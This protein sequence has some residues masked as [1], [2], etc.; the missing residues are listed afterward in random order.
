MVQTKDKE[1]GSYPSQYETEVA[2][3]DGSAMILRPIRVDDA[4][5]W[6]AFLS[7]IGADSKYLWLHHIP[8]Q[9]SPEDAR[10]FC[11]VDYK[12]TFAMIGEVLKKHTREIVAVG[13][14]YRL[15]KKN[16]AEIVIVIEESYRR[17]G[18]G[19][20]LM[21]WLANA[22]RGNNISNFEADVSME[23][24]DMISLI[25]GYGFHVDHQLETGAYHIAFPIAR[26]TN[27]ERKEEERERASSIASIRHLL[28]PQ[29]VALIGVSRYPGT[30]G[31]L[32]MRCMLQGGFAGTVYPVNPNTNSVM[33]VRTYPS[34]MDIPDDVDL[35]VIAVPARLVAKIADECGRKGVRTLIVISDGFREVGPEGVSREQQLRNIAL[36]Y[37]MRIAGPNCMGVVNTDPKISLNAT[38]SP[39]FPPA[40]NVAFLSQSGAMG[41]TILEYARNLNLGI[42]TF[43]SVGNRVDISSNDL[44]EYWEDDAATAV[45]LL[46]LESFGNPRKFARIARR[47]S[48]KKPIV[49]VKG[50]V[51][52]VGSRAAASH[53]GAMATS[54]VSADVLFHH[55]GVIRVNTM[56]DLF[57]MAILLSNQPLPT[58]RR[59][60]I[61]TN[62]GGPGIIA[63]D[64]SARHGLTLPQFSEETTLKLKAVIKR[65]IVINNPLDTTAGAT[66]EEFRDI[67][68]VLAS[69]EGS[70]AVLAIFIPPIVS[71]EAASEAAIRSVASRY[72]QQRKPLLAC[73]L[74]ER[75]FKAKL[76]S[77]KHFVPCYPFPEEATSALARAV[78]YAEG[79]RKP[80]GKIPRFRGIERGKG[81]RIIE[82][83]MTESSQRPF[84][85]GTAETCRLLD[86]YGIRFA[87]MSIAKTA[88]AAA[89][90]ASAIGFPVAVKL[91]SSTITH[92]TDVGGVLLNVNSNSEVK[93]AFDRISTELSKLGRQDEMQGV[94]VQRMVNGGIETIAGVTQDPSFG[95][96]MMFG[97]GGT[98]AE[99]T[100]DVSLMLHP[101]TDLDAREMVKSIKTAKLFEGYRG[102]PPSDT[103]ALED[104]LLRLSA[105]VDDVPQISE[106]DFNPV[107]VMP[108][109][110]GYWVVDAR[111]MLK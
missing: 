8:A 87:R 43:V 85:L 93:Q 16:S 56:E 38:F 102:T 34:V 60:V 94:M 50:G 9:I 73:F 22:A 29:S 58:G 2:L 55:A 48:M 39:V 46:Y 61:L 110:E 86:C 109:G 111:I 63:A 47:V 3:S 74:G 64:A 70:D 42:S 62:G 19:T 17:K 97:S 92:K 33:S 83:A 107:K 80:K 41:L 35:A 36:G 100:N 104:L 66:A 65:D 90:L 99:L 7:R 78:E 96:L 13:R 75:G 67:L 37:G 59:L 45:I 103:E 24:E 69:D 14:Y 31:H 32:L 105:L 57:D 54:D 106:L 77:G 20:K 51:T 21:E 79:R 30:I 5:R 6:Q 82:S 108:K 25:K 4:E 72:W 18:I 53:T 98:Y 91:V 84:W 15:P 101:L 68:R 44:L 23:N 10:R 49:V 81:H 11:T 26:T 89:E 40:G 76:G 52:T 95:P 28:Y 27:V 88:N 71:D 1:K 12:D